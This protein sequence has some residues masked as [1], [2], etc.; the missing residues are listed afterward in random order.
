MTEVEII[1]VKVD[2]FNLF[3]NNTY[4]ISNSELYTQ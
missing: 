3:D 4:N 2:L 1:T